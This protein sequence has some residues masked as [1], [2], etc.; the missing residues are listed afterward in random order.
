MRIL[1]L[2]LMTTV[3]A[4]GTSPQPASQR[5]PQKTQVLTS[6]DA[7]ASQEKVS[8]NEPRES[9]SI[10]AKSEGT[11]PTPAP[12]TTADLKTQVDARY[13]QNPKLSEQR[14][15]DLSSTT[16]DLINASNAG[17]QQA[18]SGLSSKL[19]NQALL[20]NQGFSLVDAAGL[21]AAIADLV[22]AAINADVAGILDAVDDIVAA[23]TA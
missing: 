5:A 11:T 12:M 15:Q 9:A 22:D 6:Q 23:V 4:C 16:M 21:A 17:N 3:V 20:G 18:V 10:P 1:I 7:P 14:A 13:A 8:S 19:L 2:S